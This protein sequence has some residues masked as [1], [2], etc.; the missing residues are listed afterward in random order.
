MEDSNSMSIGEIMRENMRD[1][2]MTFPIPRTVLKVPNAEQTLKE[3]MTYFIELEGRELI[4][5]PEYKKVAEW[6]TNTRGRGLFMYGNCG[7]GK[8][9]LGRYVIPALFLPFLFL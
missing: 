4:W 6:L 8:S 9:I 5:R 7:L 3:A 2:E 1:H